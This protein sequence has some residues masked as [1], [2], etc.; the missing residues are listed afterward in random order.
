MATVLVMLGLGGSTDLHLENDLR[1][2]KYGFV[3]VG[4][5]VG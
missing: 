5:G 3:D 1:G 2:V 4:G